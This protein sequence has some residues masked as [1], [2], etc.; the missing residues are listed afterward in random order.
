MI[1]PTRQQEYL[2]RAKDA[3]REASKAKNPDMRKSW[4]KIAQ[5]YRD[6]AAGILK[7]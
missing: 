6:L 2:A 4:Q 1:D 5:G 7:Y 3:E